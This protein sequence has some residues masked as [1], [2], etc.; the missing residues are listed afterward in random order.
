MCNSIVA[1][2]RTKLENL[3]GNIARLSDRMC[4][5]NV[6]A[7]IYHECLVEPHETTGGADERI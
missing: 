3:E 6:V 4:S 2:S 7:I 1:N 5:K